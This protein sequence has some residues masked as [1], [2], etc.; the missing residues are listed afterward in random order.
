MK[1]LL[2]WLV[3]ILLTIGAVY[4]VYEYERRP[5]EE[6]AAPAPPAVRVPPA[7]PAAPPAATHYPVPDGSAN[8]PATGISAEIPTLQESDSALRAGL[9]TLVGQPSFDGL[10]WPKDIVRRLVATVDNL[11]RGRV[12]QSLIPVKKAGGKFLVHNEGDALTIDPGNAARYRPYVEMLDAVSSH[13]AVALYAHFYPLFQ[14][15]YKDLGYPS[16]YFNDRVI[17][18]IDDLLAAPE[19][20]SPPRLLEPHLMY[21]YADPDLEALSAGQKTM[22]RMGPQNETKVKNKLKDLRKELTN[23][24]VKPQS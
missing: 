20:A 8:S 11:P 16:G 10:F 7:A 2:W 24:A 3:P 14:Q 21:Q 13:Q 4:G 15:A 23:L 17:V 12:S 9:V 5:S 6:T 1:N 19:P 18:V 22:I